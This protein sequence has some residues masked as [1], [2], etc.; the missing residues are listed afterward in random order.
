MKVLGFELKPRMAYDV[1]VFD[2]IDKDNIFISYANIIHDSIKLNWN[3][4]NR[5]WYR[6]KCSSSEILKNLTPQ[7]LIKAVK[8]VRILEGAK[9]DDLKFFD[10]Q[11]GELSED[12]F[13]NFVK[14]SKKKAEAAIEKKSK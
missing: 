13:L 7:D 8:Q 5:L 4:F 10:F 3:W 12:D 1:I 9:K 11:L 2:G 6:K 14:S